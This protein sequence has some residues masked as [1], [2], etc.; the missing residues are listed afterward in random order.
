MVTFYAVN[1]R[2][3]LLKLTAYSIFPPVLYPQRTHCF[4]LNVFADFCYF[5]TM[6]KNYLEDQYLC[7]VVHQY[8]YRNVNFTIMA[9]NLAFNLSTVCGEIRQTLDAKMRQLLWVTKLVVF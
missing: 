3:N 5:V 7:V 6:N 4:V 1:T 2:E 8:I 9:P